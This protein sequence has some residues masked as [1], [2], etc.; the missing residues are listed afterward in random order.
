MTKV[1]RYSDLLKSQTPIVE[2]GTIKFNGRFYRTITMTVYNAKT[3]K[4]VK[5]TAI[6]TELKKLIDKVVI[7]TDGKYTDD[8]INNAMEI[9][10]NYSI[11]I[12]FEWMNGGKTPKELKNEIEKQL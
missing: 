6:P 4:D 9:Y 8:I 5:I 12:P 3:L 7:D 10:T 11:Y 1:K 2:R